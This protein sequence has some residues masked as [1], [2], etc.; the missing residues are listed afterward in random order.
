MSTLTRLA[1]LA[2]IA[3]NSDG[4]RRFHA[5]LADP[6]GTQRGLLASLIRRNADTAFGRRHGFAETSTV[7][8]FQE[9]VPLSTWDDYE[10]WVERI[11]AGEE[12]VLTRTPV[13]VLELSSGSSAAAKRIPYTADLQRDIRRAVAPWICDAYQRHPSLVRGAGYWSITP[14]ALV[15]ERARPSA[16]PVGFE[17][18][19]EYLGGFWKRL[20]GATLAVPAAVRL[21]RDVESFRYVTL[22]FLL[23]RADLTLFSVWHPSFLTLLLGALP[24]FWKSLLQ[25]VERGTLNPPAPLSDKARAALGRHAALPD[26]AA[27]LARLGPESPGLLWPNVALI[28]CWGDAHA[29]LHLPEIQRLFPAAAVQPKGLIATEAFVTIPYAGRYPLAIRSHF[30][31]FLPEG[32]DGQVCL[33]HELE[34]GDVA[35]V[36][37][38]TGGGLYRYQLQDRVAVDGFVGPTPSLRF[39]GK[40][41]HVSDLRGEKLHESFVAGALARTFESLR[42][43][44]RFALLAPADGSETVERPAYALYVELPDAGALPASFSEDLAKA[45]EIELAANPHYRLCIALKQLAPAQVYLIEKDGVAR[46]LER[47]RERGQRLGDIKPLALSSAT[48]WGRVFSRTRSASSGS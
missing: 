10:P 23:R 22:L 8:E 32:G 2:W 5:A 4:H 40:E 20:A 14:P 15:E 17:E 11:A 36:V 19:G 45:L 39:L 9:R 16:V 47:C 7:A 46:Y 13:K 26:R 38:T 21:V 41:G 28:S 25:D 31:E 12:N 37:V 3:A 27:E 33:A 44:P 30:F 42:L 43:S 35:S 34:T 18:D 6:E 24:G 29:A 48:G 1:N